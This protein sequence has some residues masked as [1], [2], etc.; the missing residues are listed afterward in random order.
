MRIRAELL[1]GTTPAVVLALLAERPMHGYEL[2]SAIEER[3]GGC[4]ALGQGTL[5]PTLHKL[6]RDGFIAGQWEPRSSGP[7]RRVYRLTTSGHAVLVERRTE[8]AVFTEVIGRFL[9]PVPVPG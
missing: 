2:A 6:E 4:L 1:K 3:S 5:Y 7:E 8:W 9:G